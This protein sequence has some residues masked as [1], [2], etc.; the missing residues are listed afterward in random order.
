MK[1][2]VIFL[3]VGL[4][5]TSQIFAGVVKKN[6]S[7]VNFAKFGKFTTVQTEKIS[8]LKK[9]TYSENEFT[10]KGLF[11]K[12]VGKMAFRPGVAGE[13]VSLPEMTIYSLDH[14][15]KEYSTSPIQK[16][17]EEQKG[18]EFKF[19]KGE[20]EIKI[21]RSEFKVEDTGELKTINQFPS[22]K[23]TITWTIEWENIRA[24]EKGTNQLLTD[25]WTT[26]FNEALKKCQ[27]EEMRFSQEYLKR[28]GLDVDELQQE[29]LGL[30]W[31]SL[32]NQMSGGGVVSGE[33]DAKIVE[34]MKK[35]DG[36]PVVIDGKFFIT[37][38]AG[39]KEVKEEKEEEVQA[40]KK[41]LGKF[42]KKALKKKPEEKAGPEPSFSYYS[43]LVE[44]NLADIG[45]N[46]FQVPADYKKAQK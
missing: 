8:E 38:P 34:E 30:N 41:L 22:K 46:E 44:F 16:I 43:E 12:V 37:K 18:E 14:K 11:G 45:E 5:L 23:Y 17:T 7:E 21:T 36:Y 31:L 3:G 13:I 27:D 29:I 20:G 39:E 24:G 35:I 19:E 33:K 40:P 26:P 4:L 1:R 28:I 15:K 25:V 6:K 2:F 32:L 42:A 9:V 10:G